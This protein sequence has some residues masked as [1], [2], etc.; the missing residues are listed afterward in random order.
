MTG[1]GLAGNI[2]KNFPA[3]V[4]Y[5]IIFLLILSNIIN[6]GADI[7]AMGVS[8]QMLIGGW[9]LLYCGLFAL[10]IVIVEVFL[11]YRRFAEIMKWLTL[12][13]FAYIITAFR[14]NVHWGQALRATFIPHI[15]W[16]NAD[17]IFMFIAVLG[18]TISPYLFFWQASLET[19]EIRG[20]QQQ[21]PLK[22]APW[23]AAGSLHAFAGTPISGSARPISW[24]FSS[25]S[26]PAP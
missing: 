9:S 12:V 1:R 8:L 18:T 20:D 2:R 6:I 4:L 14:S 3:W 26:P 19:E 25:S 11:S 13:L 16:R 17:Y 23:Q 5:P 15:E 7:G 22:K 21:E 24:P 10:L